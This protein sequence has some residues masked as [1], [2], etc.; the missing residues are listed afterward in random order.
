MKKF[1]LIL[2]LVLVCFSVSARRGGRGRYRSLR[3]SSN[4]FLD[5]K[6]IMKDQL[7]LIKLQGEINRKRSEEAYRAEIDR[8]KYE[9]ELIRLKAERDKARNSASKPKAR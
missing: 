3:Q 8:L 6:S 7:E 5:A 1:I 4:G 2:M 9:L